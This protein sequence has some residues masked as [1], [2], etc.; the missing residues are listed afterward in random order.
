MLYDMLYTQSSHSSY[1]SHSSLTFHTDMPSNSHP[2]KLSGGSS[3]AEGR[4]EIFNIDDF[5]TICD[6]HW[7]LAEANVTCRSLGFPGAVAALGGAYFGP[8]AGNVL[9]DNVTCTGNEV[10]L[11]SCNYIG[12]GR[13]SCPHTRDAGV[14]C[15][16][17]L[18]CG[19]IDLCASYAG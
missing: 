16:G 7:T 3:L 13:V 18:L 12:F 2:I 5:G 11:Q 10:F 6:T 4:V 8:G 1:Q 17:M 15:A 19:M 9:L 14:K